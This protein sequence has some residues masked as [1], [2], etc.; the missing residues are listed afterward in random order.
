MPQC[1]ENEP[2]VIVH[3]SSGKSLT[4]ELEGC[5]QPVDTVSLGA[6]RQ[7]GVWHATKL[8]EII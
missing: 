3:L 8:S 1:M 5:L 2:I 6:R 4:F 7:A